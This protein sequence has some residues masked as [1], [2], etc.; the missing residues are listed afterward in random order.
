MARGGFSV[1]ALLRGHHIPRSLT[2][3][4]VH[5]SRDASVPGPCAS[6]YT[7]S[8]NVYRSHDIFVSPEV[9]FHCFAD[10]VETSVEG[11][12]TDV[13]TV[14]LQTNL[15]ELVSQF[16]DHVI[17]RFQGCVRKFPPLA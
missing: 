13:S 8:S 10:Q 3:S 2:V 5:E 7:E 11:L 14:G 1:T 15:L 9:R 4:Q 17:I 16:I 6:V 12:C